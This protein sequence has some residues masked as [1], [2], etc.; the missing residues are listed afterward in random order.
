MMSK[1]QRI[2]TAN[3]VARRAS[4]VVAGPKNREGAGNRHRANGRG[5]LQT[6]LAIGKANDPFEQ[7]A[8]RVASEVM[9][10]NSESGVARIDRAGVVP[11]VQRQCACGGGCDKC[12][13]KQLRLKRVSASSH[14][15]A[16]VPSSVD[17]VLRSSGEPLDA[18][19]RAFMEPRFG[20]NFS[21]VRVHN[22]SAAAQSA[23][24]V[25]A[26]AFTVGN[27]IAFASGQY[28]PG[29]ANSNRLLAHELAHVV[30]QG[31]ARPTASGPQVS[32]VIQRAGDPTA[33]PVG[34]ACPT[35][36]TTGRP[37]GADLLFPT[38]GS[39]VT[40][41]HRTQLRAFITAW[42]ASGGTN[43]ITVHGY[44]ST[45]GDQGPNWILSCDRAQNVRDALLAL[46]VPAV[47][48]KVLAHG[49]S[50][51]FGASDAPN[52]HA[53]VSSSPGGLFSPPIVSGRF[54]PNDDFA[55]RSHD[56]FG[57]DELIFLSF[58]SLPSTPASDFG[59]LEWNL[60]SG[61]GSLSMVSPGGTAVYRAPDRAATVSFEIR[62]ASGPTA[63][64]VVALPIIE[65][66]EPD[67]V[68]MVAVPGTAPTFRRGG[69]IIPSGIWGAG[70]LA[71]VFIG[72]NDVSFLGVVFGEG[73]TTAVVTPSGSFL[74][75]VAGR[76]HL[77]NTFGPGGS[78]NITT[79]T[80]LSPVRDQVSIMGSATVLA[81]SGTFLG[82][83]TCDTASDLNFAI[84]WEFAVPSG[85]S[86]GGRKAFDVA[87]SHRTSNFFCHATT[88]KGGAGPFCR[89]IDGTTC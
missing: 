56:R 16:E 11:S 12:K 53:V 44:A 80:P 28:S 73:V 77:R 17:A 55:G 7:E 46:G 3:T 75:P 60:I 9:R 74:S 87:N 83:P 15:S 43:E 81:P 50:T 30:Q 10:M 76:P 70:F 67:S 6:K 8:D 32:G 18:T 14:E 21:E 19:T 35:D 5:L 37:T 31:G 88:E 54:I 49:E 66:I 47:H 24:D 25:H 65:V 36:L 52:Q 1:T 13:K 27:H 86:G 48:I 61:G 39:T 71:D 23:H 64:R 89:R 69:G 79:G 29:S 41:F 22:N 26:L 57:V 42:V 40:S 20:Y 63:G 34:F 4:G 58:T 78:G 59:G 72:P 82:L 2:A 33:I 38:G 62:V 68:S 51:D 85:A 84:P 45:P